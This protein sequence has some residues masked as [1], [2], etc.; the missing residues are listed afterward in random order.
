MANVNG[1]LA[2]LEAVLTPTSPM[3]AYWAEHHRRWHESLKQ[4]FDVIPEDLG[5]TV[6]S[7][8][9]AAITDVF[10]RWWNNSFGLW[11]WHRSLVWCHSQIPDG[12]TLEAG[13]ATATRFMGPS[14]RMTGTCYNCGLC[15][16]GPADNKSWDSYPAIPCEHC[17]S[18]DIVLLN[19]QYQRPDPPWCDKWTLRLMPQEYRCGGGEG[20]EI[21]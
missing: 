3:D 4:M 2:K 12:M 14:H 21:K 9:K 16:P 18:R 19:C 5:E 10:P 20:T 17:G 15:A 6:I 8:L 13:R 7:H 11:D 1:R